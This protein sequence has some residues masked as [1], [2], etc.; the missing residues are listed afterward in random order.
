MTDAPVSGIAMQCLEDWV[1]GSEEIPPLELISPSYV[2]TFGSSECNISGAGADFCLEFIPHPQQR[3]PTPQAYTKGLLIPEHTWITPREPLS[4]AGA[5][6]PHYQTASDLLVWQNSSFFGKISASADSLNQNKAKA[7]QKLWLEI[8]VGNSEISTNSDLW[9]LIKAKRWILLHFPPGQLA[10]IK[11]VQNSDWGCVCV[12]GNQVMS[13]VQLIS[14]WNG[15]EPSDGA[16]G[17]C[18]NV[19]QN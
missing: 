3:D 12:D 9:F 18:C 17:Y 16:S 15:S 4:L 14:Q 5:R 10:R 7:D 19:N 2:A 8:N 6:V 11:M 13:E 1:G